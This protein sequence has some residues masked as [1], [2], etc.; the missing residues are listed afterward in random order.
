M[1]AAL[2]QQWPL[3]ATILVAAILG[4]WAGTD[5]SFLH[6]DP[7]ADARSLALA[8][9]AVAVAVA[10]MVRPGLGLVVF[11]ATVYLSLSQV[12][13]RQHGFPSLLQL[14]ALPLLV[15]ALVERRVAPGRTLP[16]GIFALMVAYVLGILLST[17]VATD[18]ALA[19]THLIEAVR[20]LVVVLVVALLATTRERVRMV[21]GVM[22]AGAAFLA[23]LAVAQTVTGD[24]TNTFGG[25]ARVK[26]AHIYGR[27]FEPRV[28]GPV[29]DP[30]YFAQML[31]VVAP[32]A[33]FE[34][35]EGPRRRH[36]VAGWIALCTI[37]I[38]IALTYSR[39]GALALGLVLVLALLAHGTRLR[40]MLVGLAILVVGLALAPAGFQERLATVTELLPGE[41]D[42]A[43]HRDSSFEE[44]LLLG[45]VAWEMFA[46]RP[47]RGVGAGN[48][49][50]RF[51]EYV[52]RVPSAARDYAMDDAERYP[53]N[54]FLEL[55][56][57]GGVGLLGVFVALAAYVLNLLARA[58]RRFREAGDKPL[59]ALAAAV[60]LGVVGYL[61]SSLFLH[62]AFQR[63]LWLLVGLAAALH[64]LARDMARPPGAAPDGPA[65]T[66]NGL[67]SGG[68]S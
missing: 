61:A 45:R 21:A 30:N 8:A 19:D 55:G 49:T 59:A 56:A 44:R 40:R 31:L 54:L 3:P 60:A 63:Y 26:H 4:L 16:D 9:L 34:A 62:G 43:L 17:T 68:V 57:E 36:R 5:P 12:L 28:A 58:R 51:D 25:F 65:L 48:Y 47:L 46:S 29:G 64:V 13:V 2:S 18:R 67:A 33:L 41:E 50:L 20:G 11:A 10:V 38:G 35:W 42:G 52:D 23:L 7:A 14:V 15:A 22:I 24:F 6:L 37:V 27:I 32:L 66:G 1:R 53:H 39:G